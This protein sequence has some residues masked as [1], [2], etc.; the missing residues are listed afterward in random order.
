M[1]KFVTFS[2]FK[3]H[4]KIALIKGMFLSER[5]TEFL[6]FSSDTFKQI[7]LLEFIHIN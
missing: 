2:D 1:D 7:S 3:I 4:I 6:S 5:E